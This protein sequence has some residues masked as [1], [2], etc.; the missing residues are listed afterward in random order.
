MTEEQI[1]AIARQEIT[2]H[3]IRFT[4]SGMVLGV[5]GILGYLVTTGQF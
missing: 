3:E 1:R 5:S 2:M 4:L